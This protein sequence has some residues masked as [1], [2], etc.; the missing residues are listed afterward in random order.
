MSLMVA[1]KK[2]L[3]LLEKKKQNKT[4]G[5]PGCECIAGLCSTSLLLGIFFMKMKNAFA[6]YFYYL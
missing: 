3:V 1:C 5:E 2:Q 6:F 4:A